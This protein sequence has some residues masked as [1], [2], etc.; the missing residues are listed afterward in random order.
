[1][2]P[3]FCV[4]ILLLASLTQAV[5]ELN[6]WSLSAQ[7]NE[8]ETVAA[9]EILD[10]GSILVGGQFQN[11]IMFGNHGLGITGDKSDSDLF[12]AQSSFNGT[13][14]W[15]ISAGSEGADVITAIDSQSDGTII[16]AGSYCMGTHGISCSINLSGLGI[17]SKDS[18]NN[19]GNSFIA[20]LSP[21]GTWSWIVE[22]EN[23]LEAVIVDI[24]VLSND[25]IVFSISHIGD[26]NIAQT[27]VTG[28][29][30]TSLSI[31]AMNAQGGV[32]WTNSIYSADWIDYEASIC[33]EGE[34]RINIVG[35]FWG[36][37]ITQ[38]GPLTSYGGA[39]VF[40]AQLDSSGNWSWI[41][42][43]GGSGDDMA[44][45]C[46]IDSLGKITVV[47]Q[48]ELN[49]SFSSNEILSSGLFDMFI[50]KSSS[51][52]AWESAVSIGGD[53]ID[54]LNG[55]YID[56]R[57]DMLV[58]GEFSSSID[59][60]TDT[61]VSNGKSDIFLAQITDD[62]S[63]EWAVNAGGDGSD[64][65]IDVGQGKFGEPIVLSIFSGIA[66]F[67][68]SENES[69]GQTDLALWSYGLDQD[70]DG[71]GDGGDNCRRISNPDQS[72]YD[73]DLRGD[74][75]D[76][77]DDGDGIDDIMDQCPMGSTG[78]TADSNSDHD[79]DGCRDSTSE[80]TDDDSD[81]IPDM[82]DYCPLGPVGWKSN[83]E[84]DVN[85]DGCS[86]DDS[87]SDGRLDHMDNCPEVVNPAQ[88]DMDNDG[89]GDRC[90]NDQDGDGILDESD[91]CPIDDINWISDSSNDLDSDGCDDA[92]LDTDDDAD[93]VLDENDD[94]PRGSVGWEG[95]SVD[96]DGDGCHD[97]EED[98]DDDNDG[99]LDSVDGCPRGMTGVAPI[100]Q[101]LD[102]D[103]CN[104]LNEDLDDDQDSILDVND[105]CPKTAPVSVVDN[106]GCSQAQLDSDADGVSNMYDLCTNTL[107]D[108]KVD[109][110]GCELKVA[111]TNDKS[112]SSEDE[113]SPLMT[114]IFI[115]LGISVL[116][117]AF[118]YSRRQPTPVEKQH[119]E[120]SDQE[121]TT[122][123]DNGIEEPDLPVESSE[124]S[125]STT[126]TEVNPSS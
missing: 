117:G 28:S 124:D 120:V 5:A 108:V 78:W 2:R 86:D 88:G 30:S 23:D 32:K 115:T 48:Y 54:I 22:V 89:I 57:N 64:W 69:T 111:V 82:D 12:V 102:D 35:S 99:H 96:V 118:I 66:N 90:D 14:D 29:D 103:G 39:D 100:G 121:N 72:D 112:K 84:T 87:D 4:L 110:T 122:A 97:D 61:I 50:A 71:I 49:A 42:R 37:L 65:G 44:K 79:G 31:V 83:N 77:D 113:S 46:A 10:N 74:V 18:P 116:I 76:D 17:Y 3:A 73:E 11:G 94:C 26:V 109:P 92:N 47:G 93:G 19:E 104:D 21:N 25:D 34:D 58:T 80:D 125:P 98:D 95:Q 91:S 6:E 24:E 60:S 45:D 67:T 43:A 33:A 27:Y 114:S 9:M 1:M 8:S 75:C 51:L 20:G 59:F 41:E 119:P 68:I 70:G 36:D 40:L 62:F 15:A 56:Q 81:G 13:W 16:V 106:D 105:A 101:D 7:G 53:G 55:I 123:G 85:S 63:I 107:P 126:E 52:G 38:I